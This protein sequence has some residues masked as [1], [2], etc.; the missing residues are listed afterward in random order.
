MRVCHCRRGSPDQ[1]NAILSRYAPISGSTKRILCSLPGATLP[2]RSA[3]ADAPNPKN[4]KM[5][6]VCRHELPNV[7]GKSIKDVLFEYGPGGASPG[8]T[9]AKSAV[10]CGTVLVSANAGKTK[11]ARLLAQFV[12]GTKGT[13]SKC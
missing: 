3:L 12:V 4:T 5:T 2:F 8:R 10:T 13:Q 6:D 7:P 1:K 11:P 9:H